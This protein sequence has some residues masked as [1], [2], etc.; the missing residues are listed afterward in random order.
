MPSPAATAQ[1]GAAKTRDTQ[2]VERLLAELRL[3]PME[4]TNPRGETAQAR[5]LAQTRSNYLTSLKAHVAPQGAG[6]RARA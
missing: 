2:E 5:V 4:I 1:L 3:P 6:L